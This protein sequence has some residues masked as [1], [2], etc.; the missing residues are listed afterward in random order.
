M[1][2]KTNTQ[3]K[4]VMYYSVYIYSHFLVSDKPL[5][6]FGLF[7]FHTNS[8]RWFS[9]AVVL[10]VIVLQVET[11]TSQLCKKNLITLRTSPFDHL[12]L[13]FALAFNVVMQS[14]KF[15]LHGRPWPTALKIQ[16]PPA[17]TAPVQWKVWPGGNLGAWSPHGYLDPW[18]EQ[19]NTWIWKVKPKHGK[20]LKVTLPKPI[21]ARV[22]FW[23]FDFGVW[24][25]EF[26][27][28][29]FL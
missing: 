5:R 28:S 3:L 11:R 2:V 15:Q 9:T 10:H 4:D 25:L 1:I 8:R 26:L 24:I 17:L 18:D 19:L 12:N 6:G 13:A 29:G 16:S 23:F 22:D 20:H 14:K 27:E 21:V 7:F